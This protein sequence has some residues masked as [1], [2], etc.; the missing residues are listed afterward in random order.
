MC[1]LLSIIFLFRKEYNEFMKHPQMLDSIYHIKIIC[2]Q[3]VVRKRQDFAK[4]VT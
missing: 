3:V 2:N 1:V 4:N